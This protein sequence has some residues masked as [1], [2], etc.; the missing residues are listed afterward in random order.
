V[1]VDGVVAKI[2]FAADEPLGERRARKI[3]YLSERLCQSMLLASSPQKASGFSIDC[4]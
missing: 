4:L 3:E 1:T 2:G